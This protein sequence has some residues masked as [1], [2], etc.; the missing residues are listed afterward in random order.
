M[1]NSRKIQV[2]LDEGQY[3]TLTRIAEREGKKLAAI[4]RESV[5]QYCLG[6][7]ARKAKERALESLLAESAPPPEDYATWE[8][9]YADLKTGAEPSGSKSGD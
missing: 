2:T 1:A 5:V 6:P 3:E 4:V 9:E 8:R 7:E